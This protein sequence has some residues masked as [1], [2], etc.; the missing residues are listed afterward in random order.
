MP[1]GLIESRIETQTLVCIEFNASLLIA[2]PIFFPRC[3]CRAARQKSPSSQGA[4]SATC[5]TSM[6]SSIM[7]RANKPAAAKA[8]TS[9]KRT[10]FNRAKSSWPSLPRPPALASVCT[11]IADARIN[12]SA[13]ASR[14]NFRGLPT[15]ARSSLAACTAPTKCPRPSMC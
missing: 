14:S 2:F 8:S 4:A 1:P 7:S 13:H 12:E 11:P 15:S 6:A 10:N 3:T 5:A 9:K